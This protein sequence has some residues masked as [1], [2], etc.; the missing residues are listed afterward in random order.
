MNWQ[1][2]ALI[3]LTSAFNL[4]KKR[5]R[6]GVFYTDIYILLF[7]YAAADHGIA[8]IQ[9]NR[10]T[11]AYGSLRL[12]KYHTDCIVSDLRNGSGLLL[13]VVA[14][15]GVYSQLTFNAVD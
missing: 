11:L 10:L 14:D 4:R 9:H 12:V 15:S 6:T 8:V 1:A 13:L 7:Y 3:G 2:L 5:R